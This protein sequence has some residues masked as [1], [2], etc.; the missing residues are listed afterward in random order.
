MDYVTTASLGNAQDFGDLTVARRN[1]TSAQSPTRGI[2]FGGRLDTGSVAKN[3]IDYITIATTGNA[4]DFGD[5]TT[6]RGRA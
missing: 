4:L 1:I 5:L 3:F 6:T 2:F